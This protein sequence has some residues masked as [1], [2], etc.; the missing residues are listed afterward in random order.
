MPSNNLPPPLPPIGKYFPIV[1]AFFLKQPSDRPRPMPARPATLGRACAPLVWSLVTCARR[2][3]AP[4][5]HGSG[6]CAHRNPQVGSSP[7]CTTVVIGGARKIF[8]LLA[9]MI[10]ERKQNPY[11]YTR[12]NIPP[13]PPILVVAYYDSGGAWRRMAAD[14]VGG[15]SSGWTTVSDTH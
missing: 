1:G 14:T 15:A 11:S 10:G 4:A 6:G 13:P 3:A 8:F 7:S 9:L 12:E 2:H 5:F